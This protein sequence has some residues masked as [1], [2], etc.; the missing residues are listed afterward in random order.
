M[1]RPR[2][3]KAMNEQE[4]QQYLEDY[5]KEKDETKKA[6][7]KEEIKQMIVGFYESV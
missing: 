5:K 2:G 6:A 1:L 3:R 7:L 4:K